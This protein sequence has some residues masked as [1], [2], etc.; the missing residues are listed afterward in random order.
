MFIKELSFLSRGVFT[1][2]PSVHPFSVLSTRS[3]EWMSRK[4]IWISYGIKSEL[5]RDAGGAV[6]GLFRMMNKYDIKGKRKE[7]DTSI[8]DPVLCE[9]LYSWL[10]PKKGIIL[11]PFSGGSVRG[12]VAGM[13]GYKYT[14]I[15]LN[16]SQIEENRKQL[17]Y[18]QQIPKDAVKWINGDSNTEY[19]K[20]EKGDF[21]FSCPPYFN[22][23]VYSDDKRDI[24]NMPLDN[25][26]KTYTEI[27]QNSCSK[28]KNNR[29]ACFV[30]GNVRDKSGMIINLSDITISAFEQCG[31]RYYN[32]LILVNSV[33]S[34]PIRINKMFST[35][36]KFGKVHQNIL[37]FVKGCPKIA[38]KEILGEL[39]EKD[40]PV[41]RPVIRKTRYRIKR[42]D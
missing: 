29:F 4:R 35:S 34:L 36:R 24:S 5:G 11:D 16:A 22:L 26:K 25:F 15:D 19:K 3:R 18:I 9:L 14:G 28:L 31:L 20:F 42:H 39:D 30:V 23:E 13:M 27:I 33:G 40:R 10:V 17:S 37:I 21:L 32:E 7:S 41:K 12:I 2:N 1:E 38:T 6:G 8:F